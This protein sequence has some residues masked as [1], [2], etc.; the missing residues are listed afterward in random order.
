MAPSAFVQCTVCPTVHVG[1]RTVKG[2]E[3]INVDGEAGAA[4]SDSTTLSPRL[5]G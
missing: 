2:R 3:E 1:L 4:K 5:Q